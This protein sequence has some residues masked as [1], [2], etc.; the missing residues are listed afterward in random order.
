MAATSRAASTSHF[1]KL[2]L[3]YFFDNASKVGAIMWHG[4]HL[5]QLNDMTLY[6][7]DAN[8]P[9]RMEVDDLFETMKYEHWQIGVAYGKLFFGFGKNLVEIRYRLEMNN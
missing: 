5:K 8:S 9:C 2:T 3:V 7:T 1:R 6:E 4:P